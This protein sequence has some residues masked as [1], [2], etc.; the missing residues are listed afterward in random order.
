MFR[1]VD[2]SNRVRSFHSHN[3][4]ISFIIFCLI[5][6]SFLV[7]LFSTCLN[8]RSVVRSF[9]RSICVLFWFR[10]MY[11]WAMEEYVSISAVSLHR[12]CLHIHHSL[13]A[14]IYKILYWWSS[15]DLLSFFI[16]LLFCWLLGFSF[17]TFL[18]YV[19]DVPYTVI[20]TNKIWKQKRTLPTTSSIHCNVHIS[21]IE[22]R[23]IKN[24]ML[25]ASWWV[26]KHLTN[27]KQQLSTIPTLPNWRNHSIFVRKQKTK[28]M[29]WIRNLFSLV[30]CIRVGC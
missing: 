25:A 12:T 21:W 7:F 14:N 5:L 23:K 22:R 29:S 18:F 11:S 28:V 8:N 17:C 2:F 10:S 1:V 4:F 24:E 19:P 13:W 6:Y 30:S 3:R 26:P 9:G 27:K 20:R 16:L 15:F